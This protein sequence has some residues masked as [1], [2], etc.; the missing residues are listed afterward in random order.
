MPRKEKKVRTKQKGMP[1]IM[2]EMSALDMKEALNVTRTVVIV[3]GSCEQHGYHLPLS[4][5]VIPGYA[6]ARET[7]RKHPFV[8]APPFC[9][10]YSSGVLPGT[11]NIRPST[12]RL[13]VIDL[14]GSFMAQGFRNMV[15]LAGHGE[16]EH[17]HAL[18][19][20]CR[21][22]LVRHREPDLKI[23]VVEV[24][25]LA[26]EFENFAKSQDGGT[27]AGWSETSRIMY[28]RPDLVR[29]RM[30]ID[31]P[32]AYKR[33]P[34]PQELDG[35]RIRSMYT[36]TEP[37]S[38]DVWLTWTNPMQTGLGIAGNPAGANKEAGEKFFDE[39]VVNLV[40]LVKG[41]EKL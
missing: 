21:D 11:T 41:M 15:F 14:V 10:G 28:L 34:I 6:V 13:V 19:V 37:T 39:A 18:N 22:L 1:Y 16:G 30:P 32:A 25:A 29:A 9:Y 3:L 27:H 12:L 23:A 2:E 8:V 4:T 35:Y 20:A 5:D 40:K 33:R 17:L 7:A 24:I 31:P 26:P 38:K 36:S